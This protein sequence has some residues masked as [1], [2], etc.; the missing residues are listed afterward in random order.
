MD[1]AFCVL[2]PVTPRHFGFILITTFLIIFVPSLSSVHVAY[3]VWKE[4]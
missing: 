3:T 4:S 2:M 1:L